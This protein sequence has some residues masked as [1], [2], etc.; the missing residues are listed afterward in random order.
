VIFGNNIEQKEISTSL[1]ERQNLT[2]RQD[3]NRISRK[4]IGFSKKLKCLYNQVRLYCTHFNF[5][6]E[7]AGLVKNDKDGVKRK[8]TP[9]KESGIIE[10]KWT[11]RKLLTFKCSRTSTN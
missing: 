10:K 11:L 4:T 6:R 2:F 1:I 8:R 9:A 3:N 7:H 5:C